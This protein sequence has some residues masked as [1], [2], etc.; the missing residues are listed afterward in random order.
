MTELEV[1]SCR[2]ETTHQPH[3]W[4]SADLG[5]A[6]YRCPGVAHAFFYLDWE[7]Q[8]RRFHAPGPDQIQAARG[9]LEAL[10]RWEEMPDTAGS[11]WAVKFVTW[12]ATYRTPRSGEWQHGPPENPG[13]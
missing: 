13:A 11:R 5:D 6:P 8:V 2:I 9:L 1:R 7:R 10:E 3:F 4:G 12:L